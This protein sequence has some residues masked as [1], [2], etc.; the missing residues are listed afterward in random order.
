[1]YFG[2]NLGPVWKKVGFVDLFFPLL[3]SQRNQVTFGV[4]GNIFAYVD[5]N[6][7]LSYVLIIKF[8]TTKGGIVA[9]LASL[10]AVF[11]DITFVASP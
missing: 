7:D 6:H 10:P 8:S 2:F 11:V 3:T 9:C 5:V 4:I 1:L